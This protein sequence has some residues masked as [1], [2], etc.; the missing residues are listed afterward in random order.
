MAEAG[1]R[2]MDGDIVRWALE[3]VIRKSTDSSLVK[4]LIANVGLPFPADDSR[5]KKTVILR[6]LQDEIGKGSVSE[7]MLEWFEILEEL[8]RRDGIAVSESMKLAYCAVAVECTVK[9]K[10]LE[11]VDRI[12]KVRFGGLEGKSELVTGEVLKVRGY[13]EKVLIDLDSCLAVMKWRDTHEALKLV[14]EYLKEA[15][16]AMGPSFLELVARKQLGIEWGENR[17]SSDGEE[18]LCEDGGDGGRQ[19][20]EEILKRKDGSSGETGDGSK[21]RVDG[22]G[23]DEEEEEEQLCENVGDGAKGSHDEDILKRNDVDSGKTGEVSNGEEHIFE[24]LGGGEDMSKRKDGGSDKAGECSKGGF[25]GKGNEEEHVSENAGDGSKRAHGEDGGNEP[26]G[27]DILKRKKRKDRDSEKI[28]EENG[29]KGKKRKGAAVKPMHHLPRRSAPAKIADMD[30]EEAAIDDQSI[31]GKHLAKEVVDAQPNQPE[32]CL[33]PGSGTATANQ[34]PVEVETQTGKHNTNPEPGTST[35]NDVADVPRPTTARKLPPGS[36]PKKPI[37]PSLL[38]RRKKRKW[39]VEEETAL[40]NGVQQF[41]VGSWKE[42]L[43]SRRQ[44]FNNR[45]EVDLKDKWRNMTRW[46]IER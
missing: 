16:E 7:D 39:T 14:G 18:R 30:V 23:N 2:K 25:D 10:F 32:T 1:E 8:D 12:W 5:F 45:T 29:M 17:R 26:E 15:M 31:L 41:G 22:T 44:S 9:Q 46:K 37:D 34:E 35:T 19:K 11:A 33:E 3:F 28:G 6:S 13:M 43:S 4:K 36:P 21:G 20:S 27:E 40:Y 38:Q 24:D 42:I